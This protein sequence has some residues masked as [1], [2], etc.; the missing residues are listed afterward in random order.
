MSLNLNTEKI[1]ELMKDFHI[2]TNMRIVLFDKAYNEIL[3]YP[4]EHCPFCKIMQNN[5]VTKEHCMKSNAYSFSQCNKTE[6]LRIY[7]CHS[8][9]IEVISPLKMNNTI[10]GYFM[11]G[12]VLDTEGKKN[13]V[14]HLTKI[15]ERYHL[16]EQDIFPSMIEMEFKKEEQILAAAKILEACNYYVLGK[17]LV[18]EQKEKFIE[19][20]DYYIEEHMEESITV[21]TLCKYFK[22][23]RTRLYQ[24][25]EKYLGMG[26][27]E[28]I[29][30]KRIEEAK[31][32]LQS[33]DEPIT[34][35]AAK[36]GFADYNYFCVV[37][38]KEIGISSGRFRLDIKAK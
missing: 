29:K 5:P 35:I 22:I 24:M 26:I 23:R 16:K 2:L 14:E 7:K 36:V 6:K 15:C 12:Q 17:E 37:F 8:G 11:F 1:M 27:A 31:R 10:V 13:I 20:L 4:N 19:Q 32:L 9:L 28:Y 30:R 34:Q 3:A 38:K 33:S 18:S 21:Q 25:G